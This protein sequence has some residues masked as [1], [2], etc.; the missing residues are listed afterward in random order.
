M[1]DAPTFDRVAPRLYRAST[2]GDAGLAAYWAGYFASA[3]AGFG[4]QASWDQLWQDAGGVLLFL[5]ADLA[6]PAAFA[7]AFGRL[8]PRL[9]PTGLLRA[10]WISNPEEASSVWQ[11]QGLD[12]RASRSGAEITWTLA[13][14]ALF[15][16]G[17]YTVRVDPGGELTQADPAAL[18]YGMALPAPAVAFLAPGGGYPAAA[19][20][21][22]IPLAG[23]G[24]GCF[25]ATLELTDGG[26]DPDDL[27][28]LRLLLRYST[29]VPGSTDGEVE[30]LD[31]P[32]LAQ[33]GASLS[34]GLRFDPLNGLVP[35]R[36]HLGF[37]GSGL[38]TPPP[39]VAVLR[40][41]LGYGTTLQP[42][43]A[44]APLWPGRFAFA[45]TPLAT[46]GSGEPGFDFYLTPD[47]AFS[48]EVAAGGG[49]T[50]L[51][52]GLSGLEY[53]ALPAAGSSV[54]FFVAGQ[55]AFVPAFAAGSAPTVEQALDGLGTTAWMT[56]LPATGGAAGLTYYA[57]PEQAPF[58]HAGTEVGG[59]FLEYLELPAATLPSWQT[60][61][62]V[63]A[64]MPVGAFAGLTS[65]AASLA[66]ELEDAVLAPV[67]RSVLGLPP[68]AAAAAG[69]DPG[70]LAVTP[71]G[72]VVEVAAGDRSLSGVLLANMPGSVHPRVELT[73]VGPAL[74]AALQ[75]NQLFFVVSNADTFMA[76][77]S[78]AY[79][80]TPEEMPLLVAL[81]VPQSVVDALVALLGA[82]DPPFPVFATEADFDAEIGA[83]ASE[84]LPQCQ[85]VAGLLKTDVE[86][87]TFQL[88]PRSWR[89]DAESPTLMLFK[90]CNRSLEELA[91]DTAS[92]GW[93]A[94]AETGGAGLGSTQSVLQG[95]FAQA[96]EA[97][98]GSPLRAFYDQVVAR[99][100]W[101][102]VLFLNAPVSIAELPRD[103]QFMVAGIDTEQFYAHHF[104][105]SLT[106]FGV[107]G[108]V[109]VLAQTAA[110][111]L[112]AY[113]DD[114]DL[115]TD[116]TVPFA[117]KTKAL[118]AS[119]ANAHLSGFSAQVELLTNRLFSAELTKLE[120]AHGNNLVL[121]GSYQRVGGA[122]TY[123]F[124]LTGANVYT[125][126]HSALETLEVLGVTLNTRTSLSAAGDLLTD[127]ALQGN[128]RFAQTTP[129][130]PF[131]Y[132]VA[133]APEGEEPTDGYLRF[134]ALVVTLE[135]NLATPAEQS[136][137]VAE[138]Q[139]AFD[140]A[141]SRARPQSLAAGFPLALT[142]LVAQG[143]DGTGGAGGSSPE[144]LGFA[145]ISVP[146][147]QT[148]MTPPWYGLTF[149][150]E[151]GTL[152]ALAGSVGLSVNLLVAWEP[153]RPDQ[154]TPIYVGLQLPNARSLG[155]DLP[156]QGVMSLGFRSFEFETYQN[157]AGETAYL[158]LLRRFALR[159]LGLSFPPGNSDVL[160]FGNPDQ[161]AAERLGWYAC[162]AQDEA[163]GSGGDP[164]R[165]ALPEAA[166]RGEALPARAPA[167]RAAAQ[168]LDR[169]RRS[170]RRG[171][172]GG[173]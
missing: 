150:L 157:N 94:A 131:S 162:Y 33:G 88:S 146:L 158:L 14:Q 122:P 128:L 172:C 22:W 118:N 27:A 159:I 136:F 40:T 2:T 48:L 97:E 156:L 160:L 13:R 83:T 110:F 169:R 38:A 86:G 85:A 62:A 145:S 126:A 114:V 81:G 28:K 51:M 112:I 137:T 152:G 30:A 56:L 96:A 155:I 17:G 4:D 54:A 147:E 16:L 133:W 95:I 76:A 99:P 20:S 77:S 108:G 18:G 93:P 67:R 139:L 129:F 167:R 111:G 9:S 115:Y 140:L 46:V 42:L 59:S 12:A 130:D 149:V 79:Q 127:F 153:G 80:L 117:F 116:A 61:G 143:G 106:P 148:P 58:F 123:S 3:G 163:P 135:F 8:L 23:G 102:G 32:V 31:M 87:W 60:G 132:G 166:M 101:N 15:S 57:Q 39:L 91:A 98:A 10:A 11:V 44:V 35:E 5:G 82:L 113:L 19:G 84:Y 24:L 68:A 52:L 78:V 26:G 7:T 36:S 171:G 45:R 1:A 107:S 50:E 164:S 25:Q 29:P 109:P 161:S 105:F 103:L 125:V 64:V 173:A 70:R 43:D 49:T 104:G 120:T 34:T 151:L 74:Q 72:L 66:R 21:A 138:G 121:D 144:D 119:F 47:G 134:S 141:N 142:G 170:G 90:Y 73:A 55:P 100:S 124:V 168:R 63:P 92:W 53:V 65:V 41:T 89:S 6:D 69:D 71:N 165:T 75:S 37:F 154:T